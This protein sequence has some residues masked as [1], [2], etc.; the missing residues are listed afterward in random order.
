MYKSRSRSRTI[1]RTS[2]A[3]SVIAVWTALC[4]GTKPQLTWRQSVRKATV[5]QVASH[6]RGQ[7][8]P[9]LH[10]QW[11]FWRWLMVYSVFTG[12]SSPRTK[13]YSSLPIRPPP[14]SPSL[15]SLVGSADVKHHAG[16]LT[17]R[18]A[19]SKVNLAS[20]RQTFW[21][22]KGVPPPTRLVRCRYWD[23]STGTGQHP[24]RAK[25]VGY[26]QFSKPQ[27]CP[28]QCWYCVCRSSLF[29]SCSIS[30]PPVVLVLVCLLSLSMLDRP[31]ITALVDWA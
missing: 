20:T 4:G 14:P 24:C 29:F 31:D 22:M 8:P 7:S 21:Q 16:L 2:P 13:G 1:V 3:R 30:V 28:S 18:I 5:E 27:H 26:F 19:F 9:P 6:W 12:R 23:L 11:V 17:T 10:L 15:I 25:L